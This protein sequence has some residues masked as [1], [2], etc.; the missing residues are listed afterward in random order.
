M[1]L[2]HDISVCPCPLQTDQKGWS[3]VMG[4]DW[5]ETQEIWVCLLGLPQI[6]DVN[7]GKPSTVASVRIEGN[8][9][10]VS[11]VRM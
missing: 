1:P 7:V 5:T 11:L 9:A 3:C 4:W 8:A 2:H 10:G 6:S